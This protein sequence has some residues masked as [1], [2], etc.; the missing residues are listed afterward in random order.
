MEYRGFMPDDAEIVDGPIELMPE[1]GM[2]RFSY[3]LKQGAAIH[4]VVVA[5]PAPL[6]TSAPWHRVAA[7]VVAT[8]GRWLLEHSLAEGRVPRGQPTVQYAEHAFG[9]DEGEL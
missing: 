9:E 5:I 6:M 4:R 1:D 3:R 7:D 8:K 2:C